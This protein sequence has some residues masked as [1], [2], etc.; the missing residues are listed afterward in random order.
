MT[1]RMTKWETDSTQGLRLG[2]GLAIAIIMVDIGLGW[3]AV[4]H[5]V[6]TGTVN[7]GTFAV[8]LLVFL[9]L[10]LLGLLGYWLYGLKRSW[11]LLDRNA[12]IIH[13][14]PTQ[15]IIPMGQVERVLTGDEVE[16]SIRFYGGVWPGHWVGY[17]EVPGHGATLFYATTPPQ[18]QIYVVTPGLTYG[19]SP[20][21]HEAFLESLRQRWEMGP[22]QTV[23]QSSQRPRILDW[24]IWQDALGIVL[25]AAGLLAVLT[26]TGFLS[27]HFAS[28]PEQV[29]LRFDAAGEPSYLAARGRVFII[30]TIGLLTLLLNGALGILGHQRDRLFS[31]LLWAGALLVQILAWTAAIGILARV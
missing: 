26:L 10:G 2:I 11:Y 8:A 29:P 12:L 17:G 1:R 6:S 14:G 7:L 19:V 31:H 20:A 22:T 25:L 5:V 23:E 21:N 27:Y 4:D 28:L 16:G 3:V 13:W 30:P 9:S 15:Q 18:Q 24:S